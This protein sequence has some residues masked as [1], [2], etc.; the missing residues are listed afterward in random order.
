MKLTCT[1][2]RLR[3]TLDMISLYDILKAANGQLFGEPSSHLFAKFCFDVR[4][5]TPSSL[6]VAMRNQRGDSHAD[7]PEAI[8]RGVKGIVC[9]GPPEVDTSGVTVLMVNDSVDALMAWSRYVLAKYQVRTIAVG[10]TSGKSVTLAALH[11]LLATRYKVHCG[12][13]DD[14]GLLSLP[15]SLAALEP[16]HQLVLLKFDVT[17]PGDMHQ[18]VQATQP[19]VAIID[20]LDVAHTL[21]FSDHDQYVDEQRTLARALPADGLLVLNNDDEAVRTLASVSLATVQ[22]IGIIQQDSDLLASNVTLAPHRTVFDVRWG[23]ERYQM[24]TVQLLGEHVLYG[25]LAALLVGIHFAVPL[26]ES[27]KLLAQLEA[28]PGRMRPMRSKT[29]ALLI[30][31]TYRAHT[32]SALAALDWLEQVRGG[33]RRVI[34]ILGE[35]ERGSQRQQ[36]GYRAVGRRVAQVADAFLTLGA[37]A[38]QAARSAID[39]DMPEHAIRMFYNPAEISAI[40]ERLDLGTDDIVLLK[41]GNRSLRTVVRDLLSTPNDARLL[42]RQTPT[43]PL[44]RIQLRPTWLELDSDALAQNVRTIKALLG[45]DKTL[46]TVVKADG[47]GH[48]ALMVARVAL[49]NGADY[50]AVANLGEALQLREVGIQAPILVLSYLPPPMARQ[51]MQQ[52]LSVAVFD[53]EQARAY[54]R[55]ARDVEGK[56]VCHVKIDTGMGRLGIPAANAIQTFRH[57]L[58]LKNLHIEGI[59]THFSSADDNAP[60]TEQQVDSF[61]SIVRALRAASIHFQYVHAANSAGSLLVDDPMFNMARVGLMTYGLR[62]SRLREMPESIKPVMTWKTTVL[63]VR[64]FP[65]NSPIGYGN[66]YITQGQETIAILPVGYADG[67]R[68]APHTW[69]EVLIHGVRAPL[70]GRVSMEKC[71]INV[72]HIPNVAVGDE[73]VLLGQ[74]GEDSISAEEIAT[75]LGTINYEVVT[76]I[77]PRQMR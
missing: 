20:H 31:D 8:Q 75:W 56:L 32:A 53:L 52:H 63:Q 65:P 29:G 71:A 68:R 48:G 69:R 13:L 12:D 28:L 10:G 35:M 77:L 22:T 1:P 9:H 49:V 23:D 70:V 59:Y 11:K 39:H 73:V 16:H 43:I 33:F 57:L 2:A 34:C 62:P 67:L 18:L 46:M 38:A 37:D 64:Q 19:D 54:E 24:C 58:A 4:D 42:L 55:I 21:S 17:Q 45:R 6:F 36:Q 30:D 50:L 15:V 14:E 41:G 74:Q 51:A 60:Y 72:S 5:V 76:T 7:I 27:L 3:Y 26:S 44:A 40:L 25:A 61:K 66:S 47:Y